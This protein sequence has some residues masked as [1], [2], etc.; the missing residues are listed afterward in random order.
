MRKLRVKYAAKYAE[1][2]TKNMRKLLKNRQNMQ[3]L[4]IT[5]L[6]RAV[7]GNYSVKL[8]EWGSWNLLMDKG[9]RRQ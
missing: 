7:F 8:H 1:T 9:E 4:N 3:K 6:C 2:N 5:L